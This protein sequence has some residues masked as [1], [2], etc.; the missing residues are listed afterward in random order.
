MYLHIGNDIIIKKTDVVGIFELDGKITTDCTKEF[1][2]RVQNEGVLT[3]AGYDLPKSYVIVKE[4][5]R[6]KVYL[7]H[8]SVSSLLK[9]SDLPF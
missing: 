2:K 8:I 3:S 5:E 6:E 9:R 7:S 1:L 4:G